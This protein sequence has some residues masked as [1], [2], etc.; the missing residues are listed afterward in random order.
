MTDEV[1]AEEAVEVNEF[2]AMADEVLGFEDETPSE[3]SSGEV[4]TGSGEPAAAEEVVAETD[5]VPE[6]EQVVEAPKE[7]AAAPA[8]EPVVPK[9]EVAASGGQDEETQA[10]ELLTRAVSQFEEKYQLSAEDAESVGPEVAA[11]LPR[12]AAQMMV[13]VYSQFGNLLRSH[14]P[15][16]VRE[17]MAQ[18][19]VGRQRT[20]AFF[21]ANPD[22]NKAE[23]MDT[24]GEVSKMYL[25]ANPDRDYETFAQEVAMITRMRLKL[26]LSPVAAEPKVEP[27]PAAP[28]HR[29]P[30][31]TGSA[32]VGGPEMLTEFEQLADEMM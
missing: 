4:E 8:A 16:M 9:E 7:P 22:L 11:V 17:T 14:M 30:P 6:G 2:E 27:T 29:K 15:N 23:Y 32:P 24:L 25:Q 10:Q 3:G 26:P 1:S 20:Q 5:E 31:G 21:E 28:A 13:D 18:D 19:Q 12:L